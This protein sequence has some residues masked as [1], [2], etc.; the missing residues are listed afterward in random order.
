MHA[1]GIS[2]LWT[3]AWSQRVPVMLNEVSLGVLP[4]MPVRVLERSQD[5]CLMTDWMSETWEL[6][7]DDKPPVWWVMHGTVLTSPRDQMGYDVEVWYEHGKLLGN[8]NNLP[9]DL[10]AL[11]N[12]RIDLAFSVALFS[13]IV[14]DQGGRV[15]R[16]PMNRLYYHRRV[17]PPTYSI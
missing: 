15:D 10:C 8:A 3:Q 1:Q 6:Q 17:M 16:D 13:V 9:D 7:F 11:L 4:R 12:Q 5:V 2:G 14:I